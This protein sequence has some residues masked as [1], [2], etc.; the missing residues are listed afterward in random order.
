MRRA[1][2]LSAIDNIFDEQGKRI[3]QTSSPT[4]EQ[5]DGLPEILALELGAQRD[6]D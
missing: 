6:W 3:R 1:D 2:C 5:Q 4:H